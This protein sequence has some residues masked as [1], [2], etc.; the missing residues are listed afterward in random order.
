M[1]IYYLTTVA[2]LVPGGA[3]QDDAIP[4]REDQRQ[5]Q[6]GRR[7]NRQRQR[8]LVGLYLLLVPTWIGRYD[9]AEEG[10]QRLGAG[11]QDPCE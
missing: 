10:Q 4:L 6:V 7:R 11:R 2:R 5:A 8:N 9:G 3:R 1:N